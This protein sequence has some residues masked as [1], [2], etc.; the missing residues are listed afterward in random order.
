[1]PP[2]QNA[3]E[4]WFDTFITISCSK[5]PALLE[6]CSHAIM[7]EGS[8]KTVVWEQALLRDLQTSPA[9]RL[10]ELQGQPMLLEAFLEMVEPAPMA[11]ASIAQVD[12][13]HARHDCNT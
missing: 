12:H 7:N 4:R 13:L 10:R 8:E 9:G 11:S 5:V 2:V 3:V 1:M 6:A